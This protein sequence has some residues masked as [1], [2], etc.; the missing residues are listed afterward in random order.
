MNITNLTPA[1]LR[2]AAALKEQI[3]R[4]Q[5]QLSHM[6]GG[7]GATSAPKA[8]KA[9]KKISAAGIARIRAAQKARWAK[10]KAKAPKASVPAKAK[11]KKAR[12]KISAEAR[13]KMAAAAKARWEKI[14]AAK[15]K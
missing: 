14:K 9:K 10:L 12:R 15:A 8:A 13:A 1:Q 4:L 2:K 11:A 3:E 6:T 7:G 5:D